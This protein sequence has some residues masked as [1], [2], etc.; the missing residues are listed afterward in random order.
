MNVANVMGVTTPGY[1]FLGGF[2]YDSWAYAEELIGSSLTWQGIPFAV[3]AANQNDVVSNTSVPL[4]SGQFGTL[5]MLGDM[6]NNISPSVETFTVKYTDGTTT[7]L[8]QSMSDWVNP[9]NYPGETVVQCYPWRHNLDGTN[10]QNSVCVYG[11]SITLDPTKTVASITL[12]DSRD[13]VMISFVLLPPMVQGT[14][15]Y[16]PAEGAVLPS[17]A[18][19][20]SASFAPTD[21]G[22]YTT[23]TAQVPLTVT[24]LGAPITPK[25]TWATPAPIVVGTPLSS[26]QLDAQA[27]VPSGPSMIPIVPESRVNAIYEDGS[28]F[29]EKGFDGTGVAYSATELGS[30]LQYEGF[31]FT[32]GPLAV[33]DAVTSATIPVP[34]GSYTTLYLVGA[35]ANAAQLN[36]PFTIN[37][38]DGT[39]SVANLSMSSWEDPQNFAGETLVA[40]TTYGVTSAGTTVSGAYDVYG[41]QVPVDSSRVATSVTLPA[42][43][44][45]ILL[46]LG[47]GAGGTAPVDGTYVYNPPSGTVLQLGVNP[48]AVSFS[49][50]DTTDLGPAT[51]ATTITVLKPTLIVMANSATKVYGTQNPAFAGS[52]TGASD[53]DTFTESFS[54]TA[55]TSSNAGSYSIVPSAHGSDLAAYQVTTV[56]GALTITKAPV[57]VTAAESASSEIQGQT[58]TLTASVQSTTTGTP[59]GSVQFVSNGVVL[60]TAQLVNGNATLDT[61]ALGVG[62]DTITVTYG[63]DTNFLAGSAS[64]GVAIVVTSADFTFT[65]PGGLVLTAAWG[66]TSTLTLHVTPL[67]SVYFANVSFSLNTVLPMLATASFSPATVASTAG[68]QDVV[69][70]YNSRL[71]S[72][73]QKRQTPWVP[74]ACGLVLIPLAGLK[75]IRRMRGI[76][77][78]MTLLLAVAFVPMVSGCGSGYKSGAFPLTVTATDGIHT[79][80]LTLT[81]DLQAP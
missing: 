73:A 80:S 59:T 38:A 79:H 2:D 49:P 42:N 30:S 53:E 35:A 52:I 45:V 24:P 48:L 74:L 60:G 39:T 23:A 70:T 18:Q 76:R 44:D 72:Q 69:F 9:R 67:S 36:Q 11:Y 12:P 47:I 17:G 63:G 65:A 4:P 28:H 77:V 31:T 19:T 62:T 34:A 6:V 5:L 13:I 25:I 1:V 10:D 50:T 75:K 71:L 78:V 64:S 3:G 7:T 40:Q 66:K 16:N 81:L 55:T 20:L 33:P 8:Q 54:T 57:N 15:T 68:P 26:V 29:N 21:T 43:P 51:G 61:Q 41:Y 14:L 58:L 37:Y 27:S 32:L 56:D 46:A 22:A